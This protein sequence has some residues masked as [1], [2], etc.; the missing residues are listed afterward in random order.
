[1]TSPIVLKPSITI[2]ALTVAQALMPP[3]IAGGVLLL[4]TALLRVPFTTPYALLAVLVVV[5]SAALLPVKQPPTEQV[6]VTRRALVLRIA[7]RWM[8]VLSLLLAVGYST[9]SSDQLA[10]RVVLSWAVLT[11]ALLIF[12]GLLTRDAL[13]RELSNPANARRAIFVGCN[14]ISLSLAE[15]LAA[16][17][18]A[19]LIVDGFFDDR[20]PERLSPALCPLLR[21]SLNDIVDYVQQ[22]A[23]DVIFVAL[24]V[25]HLSRAQKLLDDLRDT[26]A[27]I[28]YAPTIFPFDAIQS[29][30]SEFLG[31]PLIALC[32]TPFHGYRGLSKRI[33]DVVLA[34]SILLP[35]APVMLLTAVLVRLTSP[36]PV[37]FKQRRYGLD[38]REIVVYKF[39]T[40]TVM[41]D[42]E[43]VPQATRADSRVTPL[44]RWLRRTSI[45][46]L[47]QLVNVLQGRMSLVGP[48]P[49]AVAHNELYRRLIKGYM[50]RH[51]VTPGMTGLAQVHGLRGETRDLAQ[52]QARLRYDLE[53]LRNWSP[54]LDLKI[55]LKTLAIV[56]R[57]DRAY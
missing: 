35:A 27:S 57:F 20:G 41:Q 28:Y 9:K 3:L 55:L 36:G 52:M 47:P 32:E 29:G 26:T 54:L 19:G 22:H 16:N 49:H 37:I 42:G 30:T 56:I 31:I 34:T 39:R 12:V 38:G 44:G 1:M 51:K 24:P 50:V 43:Q 2:G 18:A 21:G 40:M 13:M 11:P 8:V 33:T 48:R 10:R 46:E 14:D 45:D 5:L 53:Y 15:R 4:E 17:S 25:G 23:I 7:V 6:M